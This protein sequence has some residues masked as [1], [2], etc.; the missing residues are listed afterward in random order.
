VDFLRDNIRIG[1]DA[2]ADDAAH[3]DHGGVEQT[4]AA[5]KTCFGL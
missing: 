4:E 5:R 3:H 1:E 2:R